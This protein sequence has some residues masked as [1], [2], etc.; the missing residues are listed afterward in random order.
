[1]EF[2]SYGLFH[3]HIS[4]W[5]FLATIQHEVGETIHAPGQR[6]NLAFIMLLLLPPPPPFVS[7]AS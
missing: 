4:K 7:I 2:G 6:T 5:I 3:S 1:V